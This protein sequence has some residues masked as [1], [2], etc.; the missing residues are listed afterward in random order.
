MSEESILAFEV[1]K[2]LDLYLKVV[3]STQTFGNY[4]SFFNIYD[5]FEEPCRRI[6]VLTPYK[7]LEEV[8]DKYPDNKIIKNS[9]IDGNVWI[10][11]YS[12][13]VNPINIKLDEVIL[14]KSIISSLREIYIKK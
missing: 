5:E 14:P 8:Y 6:V 3:T 9:I 1:A 10:E 4:N 2:E 11:E 7:D 12:L 13:L